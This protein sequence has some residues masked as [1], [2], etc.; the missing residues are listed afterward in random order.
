MRCVGVQSIILLICTAGGCTASTRFPQDWRHLATQTNT[1]TLTHSLT[2]SNLQ[3]YACTTLTHSLTTLT[4]TL[5]VKTVNTMKHCGESL[6]RLA[7]AGDYI[8]YTL[9]HSLTHSHTH[10][11]RTCENAHVHPFTARA[12][13]PFSIT[14]ACTLV[15][16]TE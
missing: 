9:T 5:N 2:H 3:A 4:L 10:S 1:H 13:I 6:S 14:R 7:T 16:A 8:R 15:F 11:G 12:Q